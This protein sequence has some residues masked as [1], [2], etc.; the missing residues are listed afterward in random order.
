M[1]KINN[2]Q[3][4]NNRNPALNKII[5]NR[6]IQNET[7]SDI[8]DLNEE[9]TGSTIENIPDFFDNTNTVN[10]NKQQTQFM[11]EAFSKAVLQGI[12]MDGNINIKFIYT[13]EDN[14]KICLRDYNENI[15][16][17]N[18]ILLQ[19]NKSKN[20]IIS[21]L[22]MIFTLITTYMATDF[23]KFYFTADTWKAIYV[24]SFVICLVFL[25]Y[26][27]CVLGKNYLNSKSY[28]KT[29]ENQFIQDLLKHKIE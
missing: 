9:S 25:I 10:I 4:Q 6:I 12:E 20:Y 16:K 15:E 23:K 8:A 26:N 7:S 1:K 5:Q 29:N 19:I 11:S 14:V 13:N 28:K 3:K 2:F 17:Y 21:L 18:E 27:T 22:A 24:I